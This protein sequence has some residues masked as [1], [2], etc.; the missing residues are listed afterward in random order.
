MISSAEQTLDVS[1]HL[2]SVKV[3]LSLSVY[4]CWGVKVT[5]VNNGFLCCAFLAQIT[6]AKINP[7]QLMCIQYWDIAKKAT[8]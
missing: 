7:V 6:H 8:N 5:S 3:P 2:T 4:H 1:V